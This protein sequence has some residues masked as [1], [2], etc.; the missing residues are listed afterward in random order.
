MV[1]HKA[2]PVESAVLSG[3]LSLPGRNA[4]R[5]ARA[6]ANALRT[7]HTTSNAFRTVDTIVGKR[8]H[9]SVVSGQWSRQHSDAA[10][11]LAELLVSIGVL[12]LLV[13]LFAQLLNSAAA[14][15]TLGRKQMDADS[16]ARELLD[17]MS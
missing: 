6:T 17:R 12:V 8:R 15:T 1:D 2:T 7:A 13:L 14:I 4:L 5:T 9:R 16:Q 10:F 3:V 11:T